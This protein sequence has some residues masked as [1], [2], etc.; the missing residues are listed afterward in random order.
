MCQPRSGNSPGGEVRSV[1]ADSLGRGPVDEDLERRTI[2]VLDNPRHTPVE[3]TRAV[4]LKARE[5][6]LRHGMALIVYR[7]AHASRDQPFSASGARTVASVSRQAAV[8]GS[9]WCPSSAASRS[10]AEVSS[11][12]RHLRGSPSPASP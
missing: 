4:A 7:T 8:T 1:D 3:F 5:L 11:E 12:G 10:A 9:V 6:A 2:G